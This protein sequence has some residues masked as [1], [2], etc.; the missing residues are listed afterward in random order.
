ML[1]YIPAVNSSMAWLYAIAPLCVLYSCNCVW[2]VCTLHVAAVVVAP[3]PLLR[4]QHLHFC[5]IY[6]DREDWMVNDTAGW[7]V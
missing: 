1:L 3:S 4:T 2:R 6:K 5:I 7:T